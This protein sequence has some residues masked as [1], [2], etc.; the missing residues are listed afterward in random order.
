MLPGQDWQQEIRKAV[1]TSHVFLACISKEA[2]NKRGYIQKEINY[3]LNVAEEQPEGSIFIIPLKLEN[4][5]IPERLSRWHWVNYIEDKGYGRLLR[6]LRFRANELGVRFEKEI[7]YDSYN[8]IILY[9]N[10]SV[11]C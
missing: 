8:D 1:N 5:E 10:Q 7:L 6:A 9:E 11:T 3:A 4:C 2:I